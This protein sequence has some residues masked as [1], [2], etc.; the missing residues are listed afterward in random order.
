MALA[1]LPILRIGNPKGD[2]CHLRNILPYSSNKILFHNHLKFIYQL[3]RFIKPT[4]YERTPFSFAKGVFTPLVLLN[5]LQTSTF[6]AT[7]RRSQDSFQTFTVNMFVALVLLA[8]FLLVIDHFA[9][10]AIVCGTSTAFP[11]RVYACMKSLD[12]GRSGIH[13]GLTSWRNLTVLTVNSSTPPEI[14]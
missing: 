1:L 4:I 5:P 10:G 9:V 12:W 8:C 11:F 2:V 13:R 3:P 6:R 7:L 14:R